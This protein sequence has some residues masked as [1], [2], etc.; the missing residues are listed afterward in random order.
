MGPNRPIWKTVVGCLEITLGT[1]LLLISLF[2][3]VI[4]V[5]IP[6]GQGIGFGFGLFLL[7]LPLLLIKSGWLVIKQKPHRRAIRWAVSLLIVWNVLIFGVLP[8]LMKIVG[9]TLLISMLFGLGGLL[10]LPILV[11]SIYSLIRP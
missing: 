10:I 8:L 1:A 2:S 9:N 11:L 6:H 7:P 4:D 3:M 5:F